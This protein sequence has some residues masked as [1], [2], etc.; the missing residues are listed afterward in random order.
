MIKRRI[1]LVILFLLAGCAIM[2][3]T[4][5]AQQSCESLTKLKLPDT[6]IT[7]ATSVPAGPFKLMPIPTLSSETSADLP[8]FCRVLGTIK[9]TGDSDI[10]F[11]VWLPASGWNGRFLQM[12][13]AGFAGL[14]LPLFLTHPLA[15]GYA[16]AATDD[17]HQGFGAA[18]ATGH[19]EK[20][21][22]FA[23]RAVHLTS[24]RSKEIIKSFYGTTQN[25]SYFNGC[26]EGGREGLMEAQRYPDDF[27]GIISGNPG[28]I[29]NH[30]FFSG[31]WNNRAFQ[32]DSASYVSPDKLKLVET[33]AVAAC[34]MKDGVKDGIISDPMSCAFD[35]SSLQCKTADSDSCLTEAQ[36]T[37]LKKIYSGPQNSRTGQKINFG[38]EP[39]VETMLTAFSTAPGSPKIPGLA[40]FF[41]SGM[42]FENPKWDVQ[43]L[44]FDQDVTFT[45]NKLGFIDATNPDLSKFMASGGKLIQYHGW[46]DQ[47]VPPMTSVDYYESVIANSK[48]LNNTQNFYRLFMVPG[49]NHCFGGPGPNVFGNVLAPQPLQPN[50]E[51]DI[52]KSLER[53][54]EKGVASNKII[55]AKYTDDDP[56]KGVVMTRPLCAYPQQARWTGKGSTNDAANFTCKNVKTTR[57]TK[58]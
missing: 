3:K 27:D 57:K 46:R 26:S 43:T 14:I 31:I 28:H 37:A 53:W 7:S 16:V 51:N 39:G 6:I 50:A 56:K 20:V 17:G 35:V 45:D 58:R 41:F 22:D 40:D 18:W 49:M 15:G 29:W 38:L 12:G 25:Y 32:S 11:E 19:P 2:P 42:V 5:L 54:V 36:V 48:G 34:D 8:A 47:G 13:N 9:P 10:R 23:Y 33:A 44:N 21:V 4:A 24:E 30:L 1:G 55:A 52:Q